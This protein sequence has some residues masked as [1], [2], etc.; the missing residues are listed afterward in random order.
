MSKN[1]KLV[2]PPLTTL[3]EIVNIEVLRKLIGCA[4]L[5]DNIKEQLKKYFGRVKDG[6]IEVKYSHSKNIAEKGRLYTINGLGLQS[7]KRCIRHALAGTLYHDVDMVNA[8]PTLISQYCEKHNIPCEYL[9]DYVLSRE[10][11]LNH[12]QEWH[13]ITRSE[14]KKLMLRLCY[15][16]KYII[17]TEGN[18]SYEPTYKC[19]QILGFKDEATKIAEAISKIEA[20]NY[21]LL[22]KDKTKENKLG[23]LVSIVAQILENDCLALM[24]EFFKKK[25][26]KVG[27]LC[28]DGLMIEKKDDPLPQNL[29][30]ECE[31]Y[32]INASTY[33]IRLEEK[34]M[35]E[36]LPFELPEFSEYVQSDVDCQEKLFQLEGNNKFKY[37]K[38]TLYIFD[39]LTGMYTTQIETLFYYL[40]K[41]HQFLKIITY[42]NPKTGETKTDNYGTTTALM[43][44]LIDQVKV[45]AM[46]STWLDKTQHT[47]IGYLLFKNGIYN[48]KS[49]IFTPGFNP[50]IVFHC[51]I[52]HDFPQYDP[53]KIKYALDISFN[54][55]FENPIPMICA[56]ACA[57]AGETKLKSFYFCPGRSNAGKSSLCE[58]L[59]QCF[60]GYI[61]DFSAEA[62]AESTS[63]D[64]RDEPAKLRWLYLI[65]YCRILVSSEI[66]MTR[67]LDGVCIKKCSSGVDTLKGRRNH[68]DEE[69]FKPHG[70]CFC[71]INDIPKIGS[72]DHAVENR[73]KFIKFPYV[74][75]DKARLAEDP[76]Y[77]PTDSTLNEKI[78]SQD[79]IDGFIHILLDGYQ[80]YLQNGL[81]EFDKV[82]K[83][84]W[85][86]DNK[87]NVEIIEALEQS[88]TIT[89]DPKDIVLLADIKKFRENNKEVCSTISVNRFN[90]ILRDLGL[91][92]GRNTK[93]RFW[94]GITKYQGQNNLLNFM[95]H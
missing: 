45:G 60:G 79:F 32:V 65:R 89:K 93:A 9:K 76:T 46:D 41:N 86:H 21:A 7:F 85:I 50:N 29:L 24:H 69:S 72:F 13:E 58:M 5:D 1:P 63:N 59:R 57:L 81:P 71:M 14:A 61:G 92:E 49:G 95:D 68:Q 23:S 56:L 70:T 39:E 44:R 35:D 37:C 16:G 36:E 74:F 19:D 40:R 94:S 17:E 22:M 47:S 25:G 80:E 75:I 12:I 52:P 26:Y 27:V 43:K 31:E 53:I 15:L 82:E 62:L 4:E 3:W 64:S 87:Q 11:W 42:Q 33:Q 30:R 38:G 73:L 18:E 54:S 51:N 67:K 90:E 77:R 6:K 48:M 2:K 78:S 8:H 91:K 84:S 66:K 88:F 83:D 28:F 34:S 20:Q 55:I 10:D